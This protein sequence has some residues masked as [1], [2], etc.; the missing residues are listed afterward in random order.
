VASSTL[1]A[2]CP[3]KVNLSL[4]VLG[5]RDDGYH[6]LDT[7]F[8]TVDLWDELEVGPAPR[9]ALSCDDPELGV[10]G[11]NLV[12]RAAELL[13][14]HSGSA[15]GG[16]QF[17]LRKRIPVQGGLGGGSSNAAAALR[18]AARFWGLAV[19]A[20]TLTELACAL[21]ADVPF[22]LVGGT[23]RG[24]GRGDRITPLTPLPETA[25]LLGCPPYG[26]PTREVF[27]RAS[28]ALPL[29]DRRAGSEATVASTWEWTNDLEPV[30]FERWPE[31]RSF[32]AA[33][34]AAG[35]RA[36]LLSG[37]G[38]TVYGV[39]GDADEARRAARRL[40]PAFPGWRLVPTRTVQAAAGE[41][42]AAPGVAGC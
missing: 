31:L 26:I 10:D 17:V 27:E 40:G 22:F 24:R 25:L 7:V 13:A 12:L 35:A 28:R 30:V 29:G 15:P 3:A 16:A 19:A 21:G 36:A 34:E 23:A 9:L 6:E 14:A 5:R 4:R 38:S 37:S 33:L 39:F 8:Q 1:R 41:P 20:E 18:L 32:R 11:R 2:R 42:L